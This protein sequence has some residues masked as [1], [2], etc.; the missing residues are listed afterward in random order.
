MAGKWLGSLMVQCGELAPI[1]SQHITSDVVGQLELNSQT[2]SQLRLGR[3]CP[4]KGD[5]STQFGC[6]N[7]VGTSSSMIQGTRP[8]AEGRV[9]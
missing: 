5:Y 1:I 6:D 7:A 2:A 3:S 4:G 9:P 8:L